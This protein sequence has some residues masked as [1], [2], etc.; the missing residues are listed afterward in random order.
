MEAQR[1]ETLDTLPQRPADGHKGTFGTTAIIGGCAGKHHDTD[2]AATMLGAPALAAI[3][4]IRTG[5]GLVKVAAPAPIIDS[6][7]TLAPFA[8]GYGLEV[9]ENRSIIP[10]NAAVVIDEL[11]RTTNAIVAGPGMGTGHEIEQL[12]TRLIGQDSTPIV[13]DADGL[14]SLANITD[15][16]RDV[17]A[18]IVLTPH[19]GEARRLMDALLI[20]GDPSGNTDQRVAACTAIAQRVGCIVV[21]K[22]MGTVV[23][24]GH[25]YW[26]CERGTPAL[27]AG[28][29]GDVLSGIIG[30]LIAQR[31]T[32]FMACA[33][34][35]QTHAIAGEHWAKHHQATGG[36]I[37]SDLAQEIPRIL[38][39]MRAD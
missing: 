12:I 23:S 1:V 3:G 25:Q 37:A 35:V 29:T 28:G 27:A 14:N 15:F 17:L 24:D 30:S 19:P 21:L 36:L 33:I 10:S 9:D 34:G 2:F 39:T 7:L 38:E 32:P 8:T 11:V 20:S 6:I 4:A 18:T 16:A 5:C 26:I 13:I 22:G 31:V